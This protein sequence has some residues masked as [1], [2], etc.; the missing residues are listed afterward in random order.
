MQRGG[1]VIDR[2][3]SGISPP[4]SHNAAV[5]SAAFAELLRAYRLPRVRDW[6]PPRTLEGMRESLLTHLP[7]QKRRGPIR[8]VLDNHPELRPLVYRVVE[9]VTREE[10]SR[11]S[12]ARSVAAAVAE[13]FGSGRSKWFVLRRLYPE[14]RAAEI[15]GRTED[16]S[17]VGARA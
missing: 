2:V 17:S 3:V 9:E 16:A 5:R 7:R 14:I 6:Q 1:G 10:W 12:T 13:R 8:L 15:R 11:R 4:P